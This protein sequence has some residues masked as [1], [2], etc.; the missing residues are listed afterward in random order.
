MNPKVPMFIGYV[1]PC[2]FFCAVFVFLP[3][4]GQD[5]SCL[6]HNNSLTWCK[7]GQ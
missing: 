1:T 5:L 6:V 4:L 7:D 2:L 3:S